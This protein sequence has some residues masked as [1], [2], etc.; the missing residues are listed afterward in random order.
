MILLRKVFIVILMTASAAG[1]P[2]LTMPPR[3]VSFR[4]P[5]VRRRTPEPRD[6]QSL[7]TLVDDLQI[8]SLHRPT[9]V[10]VL[11]VIAQRLASDIRQREQLSTQ[12]EHGRL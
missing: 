11:A 8:L 3:I 4:I 1:A 10:R 6:R 5:P 12:Y 7:S 2:I 9:A